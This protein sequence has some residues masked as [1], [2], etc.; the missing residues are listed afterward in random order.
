MSTVMLERHS[1]TAYLY[2]NRPEKMNALSSELVQEFHDA[3]KEVAEN[4]PKV[5][6]ISGKG[7]AFCAGHDLN[8]PS[9]QPN[10]TESELLLARLQN[11]TQ[12]IV[13]MPTIVIAAVNGYALGAGCEIALNCDLVVADE[14][15]VFGFPEVKVGLSITQGTSYFLPRLIGL[16]KSKELLLFSK[17]FSAKKA[18]ELGLI[19]SIASGDTLWNKVEQW[20]EALLEQPYQATL[21]AKKLLNFGVHSNLVDSLSKEVEVVKELITNR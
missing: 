14:E 19:N 1:N 8:S 4:P 10:N 11:I 18:H 16:H 5:L 7:R 17:Q 3:L 15:A 21:A 2:F 6:V 20:V 9:P 13:Q 12:L